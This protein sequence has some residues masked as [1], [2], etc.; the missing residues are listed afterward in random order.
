MKGRVSHVCD[1]ELNEGQGN[2]ETLRVVVSERWSKSKD[3][4][5]RH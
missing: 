4:A 1:L 5:S 3:F 2:C